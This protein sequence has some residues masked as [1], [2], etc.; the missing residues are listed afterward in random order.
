MDRVE[1]PRR[2]ICVC[3]KGSKQKGC[4]IYIQRKETLERDDWEETLYILEGWE[5]VVKAT[6]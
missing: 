2:K 5:A 1:K 4:V 3:L 6:G